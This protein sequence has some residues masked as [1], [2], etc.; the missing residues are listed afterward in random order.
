M[1][2]LKT[3][4][5]SHKLAILK[6]VIIF[7]CYLSSVESNHILSYDNELKKGN[8]DFQIKTHW[9]TEELYTEGYAPKASWYFVQAIN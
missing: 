4:M 2:K 7:E 1:A 6:L 8:L 5:P 3:L 9:N